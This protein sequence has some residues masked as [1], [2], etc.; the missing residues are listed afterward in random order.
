MREI[1]A[2]LVAC[3][4]L[5]ACA[6][7]S[8]H[9][10]RYKISGIDNSSPTEYLKLDLL[11][12]AP[13][14]ALDSKALAHQ[15]AYQREISGGAVVGDEVVCTIKQEKGSAFGNSNLQTHLSGCKKA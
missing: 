12:E 7:S 11:D 8:G 1:S 3:L 14:S 9:D 2:L 15:L 10:L 6:A 4:L 13:K 5:T